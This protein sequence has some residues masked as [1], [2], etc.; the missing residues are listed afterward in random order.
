M[1]VPVLYLSYTGLLEPLGQSQVLAYLE[2]LAATHAIALATFEKPS[3]LTDANALASMHERCR[4]AALRWL[5]QRYHH[6]PRLLA[7]TFD[8]ARMA[9]L[10]IRHA[11]RGG[12]VHCRGYVAA[13]AAWLTRG[14]TRVPFVFDM[15]ALWLDE[16]R[17]AG[18]L[19]P[20]GLIERTLRAFERRLLH[21]A[22][23][24]VSLTHAAV[25]LLRD[26][27]DALKDQ[28]FVVIP[29]CV[30]LDRFVIRHRRTDDAEPL[31]LG[32]VGTIA[33]G[34]FPV[35]RLVGFFA[36]LRCAAPDAHLMV[37]TRDDPS[38]LLGRLAAVGVP[39]A[40]V[41]VHACA[42]EQVPARMAGL[43]AGFCVFADA[44]TAKR[45]SM[46]TRMGEFLAC[47]V[48]VI[49]NRGVGDVA[50]LI[51]RYRV[52]VVLERFDAP[53]YQAAI[54]QLLALLKDSALADRC[55]AAAEDYFSVARGA[56]RYAQ[57]YRDVVADE[58]GVAEPDR[59]R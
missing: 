46:P 42:P 39:A 17:V 1:T 8:L 41:D 16:M 58:A 12:L 22:A 35:D 37:T 24:V 49:G 26:R 11:R 52:G 9:W 15:R 5:P 23:A 2:R 56:A 43:S 19:R 51:E 48:P 4:R 7:T 54:E 27:D 59:A 20:G 6:R 29:T 38:D 32:S 40:S 45:G 53:G 13:I 28:T 47:G 30:D 14:I 34:W 31:R 44:G 55:R 33:S 10:A 18:R 25:D 36:E 50:E 21:D 3:S 57:L